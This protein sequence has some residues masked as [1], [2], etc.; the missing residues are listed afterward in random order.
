MDID[1]HFGAADLVGNIPFPF[2]DGSFSLLVC[3]QALY[4]VDDDTAII[5]EM[6]R[7][8]APGGYAIVTVPYLFRR[9]NLP[10]E[11]R[12]SARD[13]E[14][15]FSRWD[16]TTILHAGGPGAGLAYVA[17]SILCSI[18]RRWPKVRR[19]TNVAALGLN[20]IG[21][22]LDVILRATARRWPAVLIA[23][24]RR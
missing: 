8:V 9:E 20:G 11:R 19:L 3:T 15:A 7:V 22:F 14:H 2:R 24:A 23:V 13:L 17:G 5:D 21:W 10:T 6:F 12:Y 1:L 4:L 18:R 16:S